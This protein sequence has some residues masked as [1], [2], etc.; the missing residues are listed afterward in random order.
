[1]LTAATSLV[2]LLIHVAVWLLDL[3]LCEFPSGQIWYRDE[4]LVGDET[5]QNRW[6]AGRCPYSLNGAYS[7]PSVPAGLIHC[8]RCPF[9]LHWP[10]SFLFYLYFSFLLLQVRWIE[11]IQRCPL[12]SP[13]YSIREL[14]FWTIESSDF[15]LRTV[16]NTDAVVHK[17]KQDWKSILNF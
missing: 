12:L 6:L 3:E 2:D 14:S 10:P 9:C 7:A 17:T 11:L 15:S 4:M 16:G 13:L 8:L 5:H 1:M